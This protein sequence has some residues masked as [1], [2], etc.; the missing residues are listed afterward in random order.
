MKTYYIFSMKK[1]IEDLYQEK[2]TDLFKIL[3]SI[4]YMHEDDL[5]YGFNLFKEL[6]N[7]INIYDVN[8]NIYILLH[9]EYMYSKYNNEHIINDLYRDEISV[10]KIKKSHLILE[11]NKNY[12]SFFKILYKLNN[13][14]FVCDFINNEFFFIN[15]MINLKNENSV[16]IK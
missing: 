4:Y 10:L 11:T 3:D 1:E 13:H 14:Y 6:T 7:G 5:M 16:N 9:N 2:S 15:E 8:N 12:S